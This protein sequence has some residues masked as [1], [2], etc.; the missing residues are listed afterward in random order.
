MR[1]GDGGAREVMA[2]T[3][4]FGLTWDPDDM[5]RTALHEAGH[6]VIAWSFLVI[7]ECIHL[8]LD[9]RSGHT[10]VATMDH[11]QA[12]EQIAECV[13]GL[14]AEKMF[15]PPHSEARAF[16]DLHHNL[17]PI[18]RAHGT[19]EEEPA[20]QELRNQGDICA[21]ERLGKRESKVRAVAEH[22]VKHHYMDR[23]TFEALMR[24]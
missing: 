11:L 18:L 9:N 1:G 7:V 12:F 16:W 13:G 3:P 6:A 23:V 14:E 20:G 8:D 22:L 19:S 21:R 15:K 10:R 4:R 17:P 5:K 2:A 24:D